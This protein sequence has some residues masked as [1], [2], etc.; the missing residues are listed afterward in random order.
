MPPGEV[1]QTSSQLS[2]S[3]WLAGQESP[4]AVAAGGRHLPTVSHAADGAVPEDSAA[5]CGESCR[6][7]AVRG[8]ANWSCTQCHVCRSASHPAAQ[9]CSGV[10]HAAEPLAFPGTDPDCCWLC[11]SDAASRLPSLGHRSGG[12]SSRGSLTASPLASA[13]FT[14]TPRPTCCACTCPCRC[15]LP[16][17]GDMTLDQLQQMAAIEAERI[18]PALPGITAPTL[19]ATSLTGLILPGPSEVPALAATA[20]KP[21]EDDDSDSATSSQGRCA[22][23]LM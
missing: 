14:S 15:V 16:Q 22:S 10:E 8:F 20:Y 18:V 11:A 19:P 9:I 17:T 6:H 1:M 12:V 2:C 5:A 3:C 23:H 13:I 21:D 7:C 4:G